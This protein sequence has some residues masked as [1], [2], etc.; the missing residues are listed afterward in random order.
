[1]AQR[2]LKRELEQARAELSQRKEGTNGARTIVGRSP[3]M[4]RLSERVETIA[5]SDA[6]VLIT[7]ES[8]TGKELIARTLHERS[9]RAT[10]PF[11]A[12]NCAAFPE[13]L[14]EAE[15]FGHERGAFTGAVKRRAG[16]FKAADGGTLLLGEV[17]EVHLPAQTKLLRVLQEGTFAPI[18]PNTTG[19]VGVRVVS[20][21][22]RN[23]KT[24]I[25]AGLCR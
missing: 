9:A 18:G 10:K 4:L 14:L 24:R 21:T 12:V 17:A 15:L 8:G 25:A 19:E 22:H 20:A 1:A 11:I 7:G 3:P 5:Q 13:T 6:P 16:R 23:L 2:A